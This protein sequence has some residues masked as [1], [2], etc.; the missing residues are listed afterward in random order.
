MVTFRKLQYSVMILGLLV[1]DCV[2]EKTDS[3]ELL[4]ASP[5]RFRKPRISM[6][7]LNAVNSLLP[8]HPTA[9]PTQFSMMFLSNYSSFSEA[10]NF[11]RPNAV[12]GHFSYSELNGLRISH[13]PGSFECQKSFHCE[14]GCSLLLQGEKN[15]VKYQT[16][17]ERVCCVNMER[18]TALGSDWV[19]HGFKFNSTRRIMSRMCHGF[20]REGEKGYFT[21]WADSVTKLPCAVSFDLEPRL[22]WYFIPKSL[23]LESYFLSPSL[24]ES[25]SCDKKCVSTVTTSINL[26]GP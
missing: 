23:Q 18:Q 8:P 10:E 25:G 15:Y 16:S 2:S 20:R 12:K 11:D 7:A 5:L 14:E 19:T 26:F 17:R 4:S 9:W 13:G 22:D 21:Y 24:K 1:F 6:S 3:E